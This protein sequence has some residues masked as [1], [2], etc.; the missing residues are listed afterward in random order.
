MAGRRSVQVR[1]RIG[2]ASLAR[3][4]LRA[5]CAPAPEKTIYTFCYVHTSTLNWETPRSHRGHPRI[6]FTIK[7]QKFYTSVRLNRTELNNTPTHHVCNARHT[8]EHSKIAS[9]STMQCKPDAA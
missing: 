9:T 6:Y 2:T 5:V 1:L 3:Q 4:T 7:P 8:V